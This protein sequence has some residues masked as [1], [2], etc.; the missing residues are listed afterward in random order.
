MKVSNFKEGAILAL[1][2]AVGVALGGILGQKTMEMI[3]KA[4]TAAPASGK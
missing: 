1:V 3:N 2:I 4:K